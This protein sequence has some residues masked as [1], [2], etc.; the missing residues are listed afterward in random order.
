M[1]DS[2][3]GHAPSGTPAPPAGGGPRLRQPFPLAAFHPR[4]L[5]SLR[6][7]HRAL[8]FKDLAAG[9][10]VGVV[11]LPLAMAFAIASGMPPQAGLFTAIIAG[12]LI[13]ALGGSPVQIGGPAGAFIVIVYG[14][15]ARYGVANLLIATILAGGLL[16]A[17]GLFR[18]GTLI[19]FIPVAIVIGFTNGIAVLIMVSQIADFLGLQTGKLPGNFLSQMRVLGRSLP[20]VSWPTVA[21][22]ASSLVVVAA[23]S[24]LAL[25]AGKRWRP[26]PTMAAN[27]ANPASP[28]DAHG[29]IGRALA[30]VPGT[31]IALVLATAGNALLHLPVETI[32]TRF[33]GIPQGLPPFALPQLSWQLVQQLVAPTLTIA[34]LGAIESLLC[35]RVADSLIDDRHDPNQELMAQGIANIVTPFF[36][37]LPA[38]GTIARTVTNVRSGGRTPVAGMIHAATLLL[39]VLVAA[40]LASAIPLATLAAILLY[41]AWNMGEWHVFGLTHL[42]RYSNNYRII[43]LGTFVLTVVFDLTVAVQVG[44]VLACLFFIYRMAALTQI[45]AIT[46]A[47][48]PPAA[49]GR[50]LPA[51]EVAAYHMTGALFFG[52]VNKVEALIDPRDRTQPVPAVLILDVGKLVA[53]DTTGLDTLDALRKTL[54]RRGGTLVI[55][56]AAA[57]VMSLMRRAGFLE[58]MGTAN[59]CDTLAA[60][61]ARAGVLL[62]E[63]AERPAAG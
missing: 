20:T 27:P 39:I 57:Q 35:A 19:R 56:A 5:D 63:R 38:T 33:G 34:L 21:L 11:A 13:A 17:M 18:L 2:V 25:L 26:V 15:V 44:L 62:A 10:T 50:P 9:L 51:G 58:Q 23:W 36:G 40:P 54:A 42:K 49:D 43:L 3:P 7:Y 45:E 31:V 47:A 12:F 59:Y 29:R 4:L 48:L 30:M 22:A 6:D 46:P 55:C 8:F 52:A 16:F 1:P 60:A 14:I 28:P 41:V 24:R 53:L 37:G 61:C 32:G